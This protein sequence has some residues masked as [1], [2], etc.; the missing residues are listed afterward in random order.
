MKYVYH[1][2]PTNITNKLNKNT[3]SFATCVQLFLLVLAFKTTKL[4]IYVS[5]YLLV[6][7]TVRST[8]SSQ[9]KLNLSTVLFTMQVGPHML[10]KG[11]LWATDWFARKCISWMDKLLT[12]SF[13]SLLS[14]LVWG[15]SSSSAIPFSSLDATVSL[16]PYKTEQQVHFTL[17]QMYMNWPRWQ[18]KRLH[19]RKS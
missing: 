3:I 11:N 4:S 13:S 6:L 8:S 5:A 1:G 10:Q 15:I 2:V 19:K 7:L 12:L 14:V 18:Y 17:S 9:K 16:P